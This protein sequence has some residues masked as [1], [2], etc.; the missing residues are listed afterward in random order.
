M[1]K[2]FFDTAPVIYLIE[3]H[4]VYMPRVVAFLH[5][6]IQQN[7]LLVTTVITYAEFGVQPYRRERIDLLDAFNDFVADFN[8]EY[9]PISH[10]I[11]EKSLEIRDK[12]PAIKLAD[13]LQLSAA[14]L[15][16]CDQFFTND[17]PLRQVQEIQVVLVEDLPD[18]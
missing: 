3:S 1:S 8:F 16:G 10:E 2:V 14:I 9:L 13:A 15:S 7:A 12:Y 6:S 5:D 4:P 18:V 11:A 17:I